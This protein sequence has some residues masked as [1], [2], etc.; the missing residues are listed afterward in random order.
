MSIVTVQDATLNLP[1][2]RNFALDATHNNLTK[3][4]SADSRS[5]IVVASVLRRIVSEGLTTRLIGLPPPPGNL[6]PGSP[7]A[8]PE[9]RRIEFRGYVNLFKNGVLD[10]R[11]DLHSISDIQEKPPSELLDES[12]LESAAVPEPGPSDSLLYWIHVPI[13]NTAWV[14]VS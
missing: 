13:N 5:Y 10:P 9:S 14:N 7:G 2:S 1:G 8:I 4:P 12:Q 3:F 11:G 6:T